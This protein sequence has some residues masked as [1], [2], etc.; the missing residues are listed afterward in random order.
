MQ[1]HT[2]GLP[3]ES[4]TLVFHRLIDFIMYQ[5][6]PLSPHGVT[7]GILMKYYNTQGY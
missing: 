7:G 4:Q 6:N 5:F 2:E 1:D 3:G